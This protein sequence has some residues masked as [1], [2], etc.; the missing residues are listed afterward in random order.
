MNNAK[1]KYFRLSSQFGLGWLKSWAQRK[2]S[3]GTAFK[4]ISFGDAW[5]WKRASSKKQTEKARSGLQSRWSRRK[6]TA[7]NIRKT[8][9]IKYTPRSVGG[10]N[11][12]SFSSQRC[13]FRWISALMPIMLQNKSKVI[14][15]FYELSEFIIGDWPPT[16]DE[17]HTC[18]Y[19]ST[20]S[21]DWLHL[22]LSP[23]ST[24]FTAAHRKQH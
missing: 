2:T 19:M 3:T 10:M 14:Y 8:F 9:Q 6:N 22:E 7:W 1:Q 24:V 23:N 21:S 11:Q 16:D 15:F 4:L 20:Q 5:H 17:N 12:F 18:D 13:A